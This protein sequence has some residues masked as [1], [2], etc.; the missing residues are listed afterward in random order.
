MEHVVRKVRGDRHHQTE[1]GRFQS[2]IQEPH[3]IHVCPVKRHEFVLN[4]RGR[5]G[6]FRDLVRPIP[7]SPKLAG[8]FPTLSELDYFVERDVCAGYWK[9]PENNL[10]NV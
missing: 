5:L 7:E 2:S 3:V 1:R 6:R 8:S 10:Q 9:I 4:L